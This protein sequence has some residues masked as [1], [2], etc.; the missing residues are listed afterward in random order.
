M[1]RTFDGMWRWEN[2]ICKNPKAKALKF[3]KLGGFGDLE[4]GFYGWNDYL[5][6]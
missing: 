2:Q 3:L 4:M 5:E 6:K 1:G